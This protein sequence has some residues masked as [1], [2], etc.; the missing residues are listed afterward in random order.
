[1]KLASYKDGSRDGQLVVVSGDLASAHY[2]SGI[3]SRLQQAL[4]DWNFIA[5]QLQDLSDALNQGRARHA[6]PFEAARCMAP[7]PRAPGWFDVVAGG[8]TDGARL[9]AGGEAR[10]TLVGGASGRLLGPCDPIEVADESAGVD[11]EARLVAITG[12]VPQGATPE[13][14]LEAVR[15]LTQASTIWLRNLPAEAHE[16]DAVALQARPAT[17]LGPVAL[18]PDELGPAWRAGRVDLS[19][20]TLRGD[21]K[22]GR[23]GAG[24]MRAHFGELIALAA[25]TRGLMAGTL[26]A[27]GALTGLS[28]GHVSIAA[29]RAQE[30]ADGGAVASEYLTFGERVRVEVENRE[31]ASSWGA[32]EQAVAPLSQAREQTAGRF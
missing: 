1:M 2:A 16:I 25:R 13:Q 29:K 23:H 17:A 5:P 30:A 11:F 20:Q 22:F 6:F 15:L 12:D 19:V 28:A 3:A 26:V 31:S 24:A 14:A 10:P 27:G 21:R 4:D 18:T 7:L 9:S 32:I 8:G